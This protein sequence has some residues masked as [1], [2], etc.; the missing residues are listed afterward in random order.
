MSDT[1]DVKNVKYVDIYKKDKNGNILVTKTMTDKDFENINKMGVKIKDVDQKLQELSDT[2][3]ARNNAQDEALNKVKNSIN[4]NI[5]N[6]NVKNSFEIE[7]LRAQQSALKTR[8]EEVFNNG[9]D[10][11]Q[12]KR[13]EA[14]EKVDLDELASIEKASKDIE[15]LRANGLTNMSELQAKDIELEGKISDLTTKVD[16]NAKETADKFTNLEANIAA[17]NSEQDLKLESLQENVDKKLV[18]V[19]DASELPESANEYEVYFV[20]AKDHIEF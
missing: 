18:S 5:N 12:Q 14:L 10:E 11:I 9:I 2:Q 16:T 13:I 15:E 17:K 1:T 8:V 6:I 4:T 20:E 7:Q 3:D 19:D